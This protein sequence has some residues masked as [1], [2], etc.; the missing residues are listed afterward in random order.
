MPPFRPKRHRV[1]KTSTSR[2][3]PAGQEEQAYSSFDAGALPPNES[4]SKIVRLAP[5]TPR[6]G[7]NR[8]ARKSIP[9]PRA[10]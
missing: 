4:R 3:P 2:G 5:L 9:A 7:A 1:G 8:R 6:P 10:R